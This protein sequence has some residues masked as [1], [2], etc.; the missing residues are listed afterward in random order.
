MFGFFLTRIQLYFRHICFRVQVVESN[1]LYCVMLQQ[2][3]ELF[4]AYA[5]DKYE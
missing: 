2:I 4:G 5:S 1:V 3:T